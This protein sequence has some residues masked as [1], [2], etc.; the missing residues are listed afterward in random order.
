MDTGSNKSLFTLIAVVIFGIFLSMSYWLFQD[1][2]KSVLASVMDRTSE[3]TNT[4]LENNGL[5]PTEDKYFNYIVNDDN[6]IKIVDYIGDLEGITDVIIPSYINGYPVTVIGSIAFQG[7]GLTSV[8]IPNTVIKIED[9]TGTYDNVL[10]ID[11]RIGAFSHNKL[12]TLTIPNSVKYLGF[13]SFRYNQLTS[14]E[15]SNTLTYIGVHAFS[16]N[17]LT[18]VKIPNSVTF[19]GG[20]SFQVNQ[21]K[22]IELPDSLK[23]IGNNAFQ[24]NNL[25]DIKLPNSLTTIEHAAFNNNKITSIKIPNTV[26]VIGSLAFDLNPLTS[27]NIPSSLSSIGEGA[28]P[29]IAII[30]RY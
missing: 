9:G 6:T 8:I 5:I 15:I 4:K 27:V 16:F 30:T 2:M 21:I 18:S 25:T 19:I 1:E 7:K 24:G 3:M 10:N 12:V 13:Y 26:N 29:T 28:F 22:S 11:T 14:L 17:K 20:A 23:I